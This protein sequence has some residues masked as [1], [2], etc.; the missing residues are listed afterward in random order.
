MSALPAKA[1]MDQRGGDVRFVAIPDSR[2]AV[3][4]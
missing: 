2:T 4:W 1:D 3:N